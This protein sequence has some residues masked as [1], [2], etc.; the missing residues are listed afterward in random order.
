MANI[1]LRQYQ[2]DS[3]EGL[4]KSLRSGHKKP[5]LVSPT[6]SGK[7]ITAGQIISGLLGNDKKVLWMVHRRNLVFDMREKLMEKFNIDAGIIMA[8]VKSELDKQVQLCSIWTYNRRLDI[9]DLAWNRFFYDADAVLVD[10]CQ[11]AVSKSY[12]D[13]IKLYNDKIIIGFTATPCRGDGRGLGEVFDDLVIGPTVKTLTEQGYLSPVRYFVPKKIDLEGVPITMGD[14]QVDALGK[15]MT[16]KKL[17]GDIV[18]N[19]LRIGENRNTLVYTVD[20]RHSIAIQEAFEKAGIRTARLD[21]RSSDEERDEAFND[22]KNGRISVVINIALYLEGLD[23][24]NISCVVF[25]RPTK[26]LGLYRQAGGR[27]LRIE[28]GKE[29]LI[30][31]DHANVVSEFGFLDFETEWTLD[32]KKLAWSKPKRVDVEKMVHCRACGLV[33]KGSSICPDCGTE[34]CSFGRD[35]KTVEAELEELKAKEKKV[36]G[37]IEKRI[38]LGMIKHWLPLQKNPNPKRIYGIFKGKYGH[39][40][41]AS[42]SDV[43]PIEPSPEFLNYMK[44]QQI[45]YAKRRNK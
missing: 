6:G 45:K 27:G 32:G 26:S 18:E 43:A 19:W 34:V 3:V 39:Y 41:H 1:E 14:Y 9:E 36:D 38:F 2:I 28:D 24:S 42:Y 8:G 17:I 7:S 5:I 16:N 21:A 33:F 11:H 44:Y 40:P 31:L 20:V 30:F 4:R 12:K 37:P 29:N 25:A 22:L 35:I 23:V 10:E 15:K 13:I